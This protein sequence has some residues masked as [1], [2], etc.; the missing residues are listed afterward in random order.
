MSIKNFPALGLFPVGRSKWLSF[1]APL[2]WVTLTLPS[3]QY[4]YFSKV[5]REIE[6]NCGLF[7]G[8]GLS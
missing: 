8:Q 5:A 4:K 6:S 2:T 7:V 3:G 1:Y